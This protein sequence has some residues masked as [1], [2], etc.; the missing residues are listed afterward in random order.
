MPSAL[1]YVFFTK[2]S[3]FF[4]LIADTLFYFIIASFPFCV[5]STWLEPQEDPVTSS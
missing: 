5:R 3:R 1:S 2:P 4:L